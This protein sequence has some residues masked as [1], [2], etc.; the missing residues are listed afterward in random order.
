MSRMLIPRSLEAIDRAF[1]Q[2]LIAQVHPDARLVDVKI[3]G[4]I[5][6]TATKARLE[7]RYASE[8]RAPGILW[9]KGGYEPHSA[10]LFSDGIYALEPKAYVELLPGLP[11]RAPRQHGAIYDEQL[12]EGVVLLEDLG[13]NTRINSPQSDI[14]VAEAAGMLDMLADMHAMTSQPEWL[15]ARP[16]IPPLLDG[17]GEPESY[18]TYMADPA[19]IDRFLRWPRSLDYPSSLKDP[20]RICDAFRRV[21]R[22][23]ALVAQPCLVHGDAHVGNTYVDADGQPA[24]LDWQCVRRG[25]WAFDVAYYLTSALTVEDRRIHEQ[26]LLARY[27]DRLAAAGGPA[28]DHDA[29][30][31]EYRI[32][33]GYGFL[34]WLSND[35]SLQPESYNAIVSTR[36]AW[37]IADHGLADD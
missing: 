22:W 9:L 11:V 18:L 29:G 33:L 34:A 12:G 3:A 4:K 28:V 23:S 19:N 31:D 36:F 1:V 25:G 27:W 13:P 26:D 37:A 30:W 15:D 14:S 10:S 8:T 17:F 35:P 32:C 7:L 5:H 20:Q 2:S 21:V 24:L 6:G 16:W